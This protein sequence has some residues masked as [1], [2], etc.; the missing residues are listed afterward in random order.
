MPPHRQP[1][2]PGGRASAVRGTAP[3]LDG[4]HAKPAWRALTSLA[5]DPHPRTW[6][7]RPPNGSLVRFQRGGGISV[8]PAGILDGSVSEDQVTEAIDTGFAK[9]LPLPWTF[10]RE[11]ATC[12]Q[13]IVK[14]NSY[15]LVRRVGIPACVVSSNRNDPWSRR[16]SQKLPNVRWLRAEHARTAIRIVSAA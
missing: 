3:G 14:N 13:A 9:F 12:E 10:Q 6:D 7:G 2:Q 1:P 11:A 4:Q 5:P 8:E 15:A 16:P